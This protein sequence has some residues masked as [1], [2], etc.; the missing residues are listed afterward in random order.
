MPSLGHPLH[1]SQDALLLCE[2]EADRSSLPQP[3]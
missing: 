3:R 1:V 2:E